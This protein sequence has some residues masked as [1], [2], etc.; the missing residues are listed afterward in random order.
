[1]LPEDHPGFADV[2]Y[3]SRRGAIASIADS[4]KQGELIPEVPYVVEEH[5]V[6]K[7]VFHILHQLY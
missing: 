1:M 4:Y 3:R 7:Q 5:T 6:W 2:A